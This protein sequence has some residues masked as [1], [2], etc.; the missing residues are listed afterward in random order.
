MTKKYCEGCH[1]YVNQTVE[2]SNNRGKLCP[3]CLRVFHQEVEKIDR[4]LE[5]QRDKLIEKA[6]KKITSPSD[7]VL[8][9]VLVIFALILLLFLWYISRIW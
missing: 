5:I 9:H 6:Y 8:I 1:G 2:L 7:S 4:N 3:S